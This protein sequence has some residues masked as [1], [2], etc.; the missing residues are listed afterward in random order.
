MITRNWLPFKIYLPDLNAIMGSD[1][2]VADEASFT[3]MLEDTPENN[4]LLD[5]YLL[6]L[7][8]ETERKK[9]ERP[10]VL[11]QAIQAHKEGLLSLPYSALGVKERKLLMNLP[12]TR[13]EEDAIIL[14][15]S[16]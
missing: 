2:I 7:D 6:S 12:L 1:G 3:L 11:N 8:E 10:T 9:L 5:S 15:H 14:E 4:S 13:E 16:P